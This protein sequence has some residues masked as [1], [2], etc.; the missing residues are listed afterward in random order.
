MQILEEWISHFNLILVVYP[1]IHQKQGE[2]RT[3]QNQSDL[4][5][6]NK[7]RVIKS[8]KKAGNQMAITSHREKNKRPPCVVEKL[9]LSSPDSSK[10]QQNKKHETQVVTSLGDPIP[11]DRIKL[12]RKEKGKGGIKQRRKQ[13]PPVHK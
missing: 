8:I 5:T 13:H 11:D 1:S 6:R 2:I 4:Y 7:T 12:K 10:H 3:N 9:K